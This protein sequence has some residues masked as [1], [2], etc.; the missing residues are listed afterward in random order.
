[1]ANSNEWCV[2]IDLGRGVC[3]VFKFLHWQ[4]PQSVICGKLRRTA[5]GAAPHIMMVGSDWVSEKRV[6]SGTHFFF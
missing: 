6:N 5:A 2:G 4:S 1:M 3:K